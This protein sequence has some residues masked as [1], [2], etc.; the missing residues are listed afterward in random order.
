MPQLADQLQSLNARNGQRFGSLDEQ[1]ERRIC[2]FKTS[3]HHSLEQKLLQLLQLLQLDMAVGQ[4][5][6][7]HS[8]S[9]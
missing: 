9:L 2:K 8:D 1:N 5:P 3:I 4:D 7:V 6:P